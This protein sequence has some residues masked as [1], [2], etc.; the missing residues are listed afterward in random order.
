MKGLMIFRKAI[1]GLSARL[2]LFG[3][4]LL[5]LMVGI[6]IVDILLRILFRKSVPGGY[7]LL[8]YTMVLVI[9]FGLG[10]TQIKRGHTEVT[11]LINLFPKKVRAIFNRL[12]TLLGSVTFALI[13]WETFL[14]G[15]LDMKAGETSA[16]LFI[17]KYPFVYCATVGFALLAIIFALQTFLPEEDTNKHDTGS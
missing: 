12:A 2:N 4:T 14:K 9:T 7:E 1:Y 10:Y 15:G 17:P 3:V 11:S 8:E 5:L 6:T 16:V 13:S